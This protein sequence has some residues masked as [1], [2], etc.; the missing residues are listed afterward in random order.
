MT[1]FNKRGK[2][3]FMKKIQLSLLLSCFLA[4]LASC[5]GWHLRGSDNSNYT[6]ASNSVYISG[7]PSETYTLLEQQLTKKQVLTTLTTAQLQLVLGKEEWQRRSVSRNSSNQVS[8]YELTLT[9]NYRV[10]DNMNNTLRTATDIRITRSYTNDQNDIAG[11]DKEELLIRQ[12]MRRA[13]AR[14]LLQQLQFVK[15]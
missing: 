14:Q 7:Q 13:A 1:T 5:T 9:I 15:P 8:E 10:L 6:L 3:R 11:K 4:V 12:D 2:D